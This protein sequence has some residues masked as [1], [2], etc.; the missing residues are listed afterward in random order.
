M[1]LRVEPFKLL[2]YSLFVAS[3]SEYTVGINVL[4]A[5][6]YSSHK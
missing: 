6:T 1:T 5:F 3:R 4:Y 2:L